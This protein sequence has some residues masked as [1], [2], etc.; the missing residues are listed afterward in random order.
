MVTSSTPPA[1]CPSTAQRWRAESWGDQL[2]A[3]EG[4]QA[5]RLAVNAVPDFADHTHV[6]DGASDLLVAVFGRAGSHARL[7][8]GVSSLP[9][10]M[11]L[12]VQAVIALREA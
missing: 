10:N 2:T 6:V 11:A 9:A 8:I 1:T 7:A 4:Y 5:A 3:D 12:E